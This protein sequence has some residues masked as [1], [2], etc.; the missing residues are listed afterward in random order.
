MEVSTVTFT[1][2]VTVMLAGYGLDDG[3]HVSPDL[4]STRK[5]SGN[6]EAF[7]NGGITSR[8]NRLSA[9]TVGIVSALKTRG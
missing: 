4:T 8:T 5:S 6:C 3:T 7:E 9:R 1:R 2:F